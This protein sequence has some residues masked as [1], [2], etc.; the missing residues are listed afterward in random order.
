MRPPSNHSRWTV[1][2]FHAFRSQLMEPC[3]TAVLYVVVGTDD[4]N[5]GSGDLQPDLRSYVTARTG[6]QVRG[7]LGSPPI[8]SCRIP[9]VGTLNM[10]VRSGV[11]AIPVNYAC[12]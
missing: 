6:D 3:W 1:R 4:L 5:G 2:P 10:A 8:G 7:G 11:F 9:P 12:I